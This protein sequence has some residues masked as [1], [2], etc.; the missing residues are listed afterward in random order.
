MLTS[1][2][3]TA[4][5]KEEIGVDFDDLERRLRENGSC[6]ELGRVWIGKGGC[7]WIAVERTSVN[8]QK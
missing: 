8:R 1:R 5:N 7:L 2:E 6:M 3:N 4:S